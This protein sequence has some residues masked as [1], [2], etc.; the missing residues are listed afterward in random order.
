[1][2]FAKVRKINRVICIV[3]QGGTMRLG[4]PVFGEFS[5]PAQWVQAVK[6]LGYRAAYCPISTDADDATVNAYA[7]AAKSADLVIAEVGAWHNN[8]L[9]ADAATRNT[10]LE[11]CKK[12]LALAERIG[13]RCC[14]NVA[15][16]RGERWDGPAQENFTE[17]TFEQIVVTVR[18][19]ID[20]VQPTR[21]FY[22]LEPMP[23]MYPDSVDSYLRLIEAIDRKAFAVHL[24]P[25][26]M[27]SSPQLYYA[28]TAFVKDCI[29]RLGPYIKSCHAK[30]IVLQPKLTVHLDEVRPGLG[31]LDYRTLL[32][33]LSKLDADMPLMVEHLQNPND[34]ILAADYIRSVAT[35]EGIM[36]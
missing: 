9:S 14:V 36:L 11:N 15:G 32:R 1:M 21:T 16:S 17:E 33:E 13:A 18:E 6:A 7:A 24:D 20:S 23:Y 30:D 12:S 26:N 35:A 2:N 4:G 27:I 31:T 19:I 5:D 28:N 8:P 3:E 25:V 10:A 22:T 34:Y 29:A